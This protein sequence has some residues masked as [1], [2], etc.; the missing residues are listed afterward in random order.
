[1]V[2]P[3]I[4]GLAA[5]LTGL[6]CLAL[7]GAG[8]AADRAGSDTNPGA[9][10]GSAQRRAAEQYL[11]ALASGDARAIAQTIQE[12]ELAQLRRSLLDQMKLEADRNEDVVR[13]RLFGPGMPLTDI[14]RLTPQ[15]F[16]VALAP[17]LHFSGRDRKSVV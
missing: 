4:R 12:D 1:M 11:A 2:T 17:R 16:F 10:K 15:N 13:A 6:A 7:G 8:V 3:R 14:E 9:E 5:I